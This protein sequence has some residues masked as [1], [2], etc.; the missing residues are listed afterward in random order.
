M[1]HLLTAIGLQPGGSSTVHIYAQKTRRTTQN[2]QYIEQLKKFEITKILG[3]TQ[4]FWKQHK[5]VKSP[6][7]DKFI[8]ICGCC[9]LCH[10]RKSAI[11][12]K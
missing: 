1:I 4:T 3:L 2:K 7:F 10:I 5:N 11:K 12:L 6:T 8:V 9:S